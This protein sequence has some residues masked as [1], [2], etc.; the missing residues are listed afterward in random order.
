MDFS[1]NYSIYVRNTQHYDNIIY[2]LRD[3]RNDVYQYIGKST[4]GNKRALQHLFK[5]HSDKVN[6]WISS[7][8]KDWLYPLVDII[9]EVDLVEELLEREKYWIEYYYNLNPDLLN[10]NSKPKEINN[11][12]TEEDEN[13]FNYLLK[14]I[15]QLPVMLKKQRLV[16]NISQ[17][18]LAKKMGVNRWTI[19]QLENG[20]SVNLKYV[21]KYVLTLKGIYII[22]KSYNERIR[23]T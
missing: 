9:E 1:F 10:I 19:S 5:S 21:H 11:I 16:R 3:P 17:E 8:E 20:N 22:H 18:E 7:L 4:V 15:S 2:G 14:I 23:R 6:D 13:D 12:L